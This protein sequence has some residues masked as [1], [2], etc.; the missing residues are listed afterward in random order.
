MVFNAS[1]KEGATMTDLMD[2][3]FTAIFNGFGTA[4]GLYIFTH[5]LKPRLDRA[6]EYDFS[7]KEADGIKQ[8][9]G[10]KTEIKKKIGNLLE[11]WEKTVG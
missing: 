4:I 11:E 8:A 2:M 6:R 10:K 3:V 9:V 7:I 5:F 1:D